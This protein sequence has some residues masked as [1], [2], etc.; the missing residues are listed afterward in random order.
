MCSHV[1]LFRTDER[2]F[3]LLEPSCFGTSI[4]V[5]TRLPH[6]IRLIPRQSFYEELSPPGN[7]L[8]LPREIWRLVNDLMANGADLVRPLTGL[9]IMSKLN[10]IDSV[11]SRGFFLN[12]EI[13]ASWRPFA[14]SAV[15]PSVP[16]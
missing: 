8:S 16:S 7:A 4:E 12:A 2:H 3:D 6:P 15:T 9:S 14:R 5:L 1:Q 13:H 11:G 10:I